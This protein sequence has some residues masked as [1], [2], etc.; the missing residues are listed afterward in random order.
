MKKLEKKI[1]EAAIEYSKTS[2]DRD[3][4]QRYERFAFMHGALSSEAEEYHNHNLK[5]EMVAKC[6]KLQVELKKSLYTE[7]E[8]K[9]IA[10]KFFYHWYNV[11]GTNTEEGFDK[12]FN[13][14]KKK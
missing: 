14:I 3:S 4:I 13:T 2:F 8:V 9:S 12:W 11:G 5:I 10:T 6:A 7:E 1:K